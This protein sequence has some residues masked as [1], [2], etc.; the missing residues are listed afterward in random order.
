MSYEFLIID[1][2]EIFK[3]FR[4]AIWLR[5]KIPKILRGALEVKKRIL[6][7]FRGCKKRA[8]KK[9]SNILIL[10]NNF[11]KVEGLK[12]K[13]PTSAQYWLRP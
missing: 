10:Y 1:K 2:K 12:E 6:K 13:F 7:N 3:H 5:K 11:I 8:T 4:G 9:F